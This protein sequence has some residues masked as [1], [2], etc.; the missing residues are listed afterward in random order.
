MKTYPFLSLKEITSPMA[1]ELK[2]AVGEVIDSGWFINGAKVTDFEEALATL[3]ETKYA[4][5]LS[6]G[7]DALR[8]ILR[9]YIELGI[10]RKG[11]EIIVPSNTYIAS[12]LAIT[13]CELTPIFVEPSENTMNLDISR[14]EEKISKRTRGIMV[15][16]LYGT[17]CWSNQL[18]DI[19]KKY[20]L[21]I[22]EDNAQA[23]GARTTTESI[24]GT[25]TTGGL[26]DAAGN[27]FYPTKNLGA[28]GD[29]G[30][31]TTNDEV[32]ANTI[33]A[34]M[35]YGS[36]YRYHNIYKGL[37]CRLD[38][39]QAAILLVKLRH[40][41]SENTHR[42]KIAAIYNEN[43]TNPFIKKPASEN[44]QN[45]VW[46]QYVV[47][48]EQRTHFKAYLDSNGIGNDILYPTPPHLQPCYKEYSGLEL[49]IAERISNTVISI[50]ISSLTTAEDAMEISR[51]I[52]RF[53]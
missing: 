6:N 42:K 25:F 3:C 18:K 17:P 14:I 52:N 22:I 35:N 51:I 12:V 53:Q 39:I 27:S 41:E 8:L 16:H 33:R 50:P 10:M 47:R 49:P 26:G 1:S 32:L 29:A 36:D 28:L 4:I 20:N 37:N 43:I 9:A 30:A 46:H 15:V 34:I 7:L 5:G 19:A 13:D 21:K 31:V 44:I 2:Q 48:T 45:C 11:D 23:I 40:L 38:E 24:N